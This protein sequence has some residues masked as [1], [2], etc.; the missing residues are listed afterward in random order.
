MILLAQESDVS[1]ELRFLDAPPAWMIVLVIVPALIGLVAYV[2]RREASSASRWAKTGMASLRILAVALVLLVLF[3][4]VNRRQVFSVSRSIVALLLDESASMD[5]HEEYDEDL[6]A[7]LANAVGLEENQQVREFTRAEL[8]KKA[9]NRPE[10]SLVGRLEEQVD[11]EFY[12][13]ANSTRTLSNVGEAN[14]EGEATALGDA[15]LTAVNDLRH[16]NL[17]AV[18]VLTDGQSNRGRDPLDVGLVAASEGIPVHTVGVGNPSAPRNVA[19]L[20]V[21]GPDVALIGDMVAIDVTIVSQGYESEPS[22][23][24]VRDRDTGMELA[25]RSFALT[26]RGSQQPETVFFQP[27]EEGEFV[28]EISLPERPGEQFSD[29]NRRFH[30]LRVEPE[31][32]QV[33]YVEGRPR[34]EYRYLKNLLLRANNFKVQCLLV[35]A[36]ADFIQESSEGVPALLRFPPTRKDLFQYDVIILGDVAPDEIDVLNSRGA[37]DELLRDIRDFVTVGGGFIMVAGQLHSPRD[38]RDTSIGDILPVEIGNPEEMRSEKQDTRPFRPRLPDPARPHDIVRLSTDLARNR[39][40]LENEDVGLAPM[41]WYAAVR[42]AKPGAEVI[43]LHPSN[44]NRYGPHVL[45]ASTHI[46]SGRTLYIGFDE[47]WLWRKPYGDRY[48]ERFWRAAVRHVAI[49]KLRSSDKR[50]ELRTDKDRYNLGDPIQVSVRV[51]D[52]D[53]RPSRE[54]TQLIRVQRGEGQVEDWKTYRQ[55]DGFYERTIRAGVPGTFRFWIEDPSHPEKRLAMKAVEV[56]IPTLEILNPTLDQ[57]RLASLAE[58]TAG[59]AL[60][61]H[62]VKELEQLLKGESRRIPVRT[63]QKD[64]W[65]RWEVILI[66]VLLLGTEWAVRK[67]YNLL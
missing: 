51:R 40:L 64:L 16:R 32:I 52:Q 35:S 24:V 20:E 34:W 12:G 4:P 47:T 65:D 6:A 45:A 9:L 38:Y 21:V 29:D 37:T 53:F 54:E 67:R 7:E 5:R 59:K 3:Q 44:A 31:V 50:F 22:E 66:L 26:G 25:A 28:L 30:H 56:Q 17:S 2:Y 43:L 11:L 10:D 14:S 33:L 49:G 27:E 60:G 36:S 13:F 18:V 1:Q 8:V 15:L 23:L 39:T 48:T 19:I 41:R 63:E 58:M 57:A 62:Q 46:P 61:L 42:R 55:E